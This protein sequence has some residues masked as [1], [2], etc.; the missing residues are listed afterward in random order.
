MSK[1][2][3]ADTIRSRAKFSDHFEDPESATGPEIKK[4]LIMHDRRMKALDKGWVV[5]SSFWLSQVGESGELR[6][7]SLFKFVG[8]RSRKQVKSVT[9]WVEMLLTRRAPILADATGY[10]FLGQVVNRFSWFQRV[11]AL[12]HADKPSRGVL[13]W[14]GRLDQVVLDGASVRP[15]KIDMVT[16]QFF[17]VHRWLMTVEQGKH[18]EQV[19]TEVQG[20]VPDLLVVSVERACMAQAATVVQLAS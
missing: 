10:I 16:L 5:E 17:A 20:N 15:E 19:T 12:L 18:I 14:L 1:E 2:L 3:L 9:Q 7:S 11:D 8:V 6:T 4:I 13:Q